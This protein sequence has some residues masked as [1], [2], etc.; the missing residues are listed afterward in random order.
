M[1][2]SPGVYSTMPFCTITVWMSAVPARVART[3]GGDLDGDREL[4]DGAVVAG[5]VGV[6]DHDELGWAG[7]WRAWSPRLLGG[8][9]RSLIVWCGVVAGVSGAG[10]RDVD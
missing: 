4:G 2:E 1:F 5:G 10:F 9:G 3:R 7:P 8:T 6:D